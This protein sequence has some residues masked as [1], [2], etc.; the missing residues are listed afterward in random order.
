[1]EVARVRVERRDLLLRGGDDPRMAVAHVAD[2]VHTVE[3]APAVGVEEVL[4]GAAHDLE[5]RAV[6]DAQ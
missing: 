5:G 4:A 2:V 1:M 3:E 6:G